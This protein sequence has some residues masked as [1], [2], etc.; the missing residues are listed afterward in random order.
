MVSDCVLDVLLAVM[1]IHLK[2]KAV[3][4]Y[5]EQQ[6]Q[7]FPLTDVGYLFLTTCIVSMYR[8][9][10]EHTQVLEFLSASFCNVCCSCS[11]L[12]HTSMNLTVEV[13]S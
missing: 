13:P 12:V 4:N 3:G 9:H 8:H 11:V 10:P 1:Y 6:T 7:V 5:L 2:C